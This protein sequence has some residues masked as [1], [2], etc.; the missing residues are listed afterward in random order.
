MMLRSLGAQ[1]ISVSSAEE[2]LEKLKELASSHSPKIVLV[3]LGLPDMDGSDF[4]RHAKKIQ[5]GAGCKYVIAS[6]NEDIRDISRAV[7]ADGCLKKPISAADMRQVY[8][9]LTQTFN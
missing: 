9:D 4:I 8:L 3:D 6:G 2:A 5:S 1:P 7:G